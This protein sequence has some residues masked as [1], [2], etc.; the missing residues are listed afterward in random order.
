MN[1]PK[2]K[3]DLEAALFAL[4]NAKRAAHSQTFFKTQVGQYGHGDVFL[5]IDVPTQRALAK[6]YIHLPLDAL[7]DLLE[8]KYHEIRLTGL[9]ILVYMHKKKLNK[10]QVLYDFYIAHLDQVN[11]WDLVDSTA[12][13]LVGEYFLNK[14][15]EPL[16]ALLDASELFYRRVAVVATLTFI[17]NN[18]F[19]PTLH[20][21]QKLLYDKEDL[22]HKAVGWMLREVGK[23]NKSVLQAFLDT[24]APAMP[25]TMLRYAIEKCS[26]IER[27]RYLHAKTWQP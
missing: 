22:I 10:P 13:T 21:A 3:N 1:V 26:P 23:R 8:S 27:A 5:G 12:P 14:P 7:S 19:Q 4:G 17:R 25:R 15:L 20:C 11:N 2:T 24:H 16:F 6:S 9:L 18:L